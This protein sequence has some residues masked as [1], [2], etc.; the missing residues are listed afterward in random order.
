MDAPNL[1]IAD[2]SEEFRLALAGVLQEH[3]HVHCSSDGKESL[4]ILRRLKPEV[5]VLDLMLPELDGISLLQTASEEGLCPKVLATTPLVSD[6]VLEAADHLGVGYLIRKPCDVQA[7]AMR[8]G[9]LTNRLHTHAAPVDSHAYISDVLLSLGISP[10]HRGYHYLREAIVLMAQ[11]P[12]Q[13]VTKVL[14][15]EVAR[16]C[17]AEPRHVERSIRSALSVAWEHRDPAL[18]EQ[19][20]PANLHRCPTNAV[21][22]SRLAELLR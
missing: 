8:V 15:P 18:W 9:D 2:S 20:F 3:Y 10:K 16:L 11:S 5:L 1:L 22:I 7:T 4:D 12:G 19:Y 13:S 14:Y 6:Y 17:D 21:F